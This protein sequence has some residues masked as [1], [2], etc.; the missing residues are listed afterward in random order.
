MGVFCLASLSMGQVKYLSIGAVDFHPMYG[1]SAAYYNW[2]DLFITP[3]LSFS[4]Y[5]TVSIYRCTST[6]MP[7]GCSYYFTAPVHLPANAS[8]IRWV[9]L[10]AFDYDTASGKNVYL[11]LIRVNKYSGQQEVVFK[12]DTSSVSN[13]TQVLTVTTLT[14]L[15]ASYSLVNNGVCSYYV[16]VYIPSATTDNTK[17]RLYGCTIG[18]TEL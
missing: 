4:L 7:G 6:T 18:F 8:R 12:C 14:P 2:D 13:E 17:L 11:Y 5:A 10:H 1:N 16:Y 15:S 3:D 9:K